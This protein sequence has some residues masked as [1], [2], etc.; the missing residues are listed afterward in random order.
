M[1]G[2]PIHGVDA[3]RGMYQ[4][5]GSRFPGLRQEPGETW[6]SGPEVAVAV[7]IA[8]E[9]EAQPGMWIFRFDPAGRIQRVSALY[10]PRPIQLKGSPNPA[11]GGPAWAG[12]P[13][14]DLDPV[15]RQALEAYFETYNAGDEEGHLAL[16]HPE[17]AFHGSMTRLDT[18][19]I[20]T[21]RGVHR[22]AKETMKV[23]RLEPLRIFGRR[24]ELAVLAAF[25]PG[26]P[27]G[28]AIR[29]VW[30]FRLD[31]AGRIDQLS[32]L[33]NTEGLSRG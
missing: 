7:D 30:A 16:F 5:L 28:P 10:D 15:P 3:L 6:G 25:A 24:Q 17:V 19:G 23:S 26:N 12:V 9:G 33:W 2:V 18:T 29:G 32:V 4:A 22:A 27:P 13:G 8:F 20:A 11:A 14:G 21:V 31:P 1:S